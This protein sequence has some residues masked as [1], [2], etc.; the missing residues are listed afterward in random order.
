MA[1]KPIPRDPV[2]ELLKAMRPQV[3]DTFDA[4]LRKINKDAAKIEDKRAR[5]T[6]IQLA[7]DYQVAVKDLVATKVPITDKG[8]TFVKQG[9][10]GLEERLATLIHGP[11][12][13]EAKKA[14]AAV[15]AE[16][17]QQHEESFWS[18]K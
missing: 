6:L 17:D 5:E 3:I 12:S 10:L 11:D 7:N 13:K 15:L 18:T 1:K 9:I 4:R 16:H 2:S 14:S 8:F